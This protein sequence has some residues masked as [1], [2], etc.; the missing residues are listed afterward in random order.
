MQGAQKDEHS[1]GMDAAH[2]GHA[3]GSGEV[4]AD[5]HDAASE[6]VGKGAPEG[7]GEAHADGRGEGEE[8]DPQGE[9]FAGGDAEVLLKEERD[10]G[11]R[12]R[13][14]KALERS[15][16]NRKVAAGKVGLSERTLYRK[17]KEYGL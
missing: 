6:A 12:E 15:G 5:Q 4:G 1:R 13:I 14:I 9:G 8:R 16:G 17:I 10:E 3:D 11:E 7:G 2:E